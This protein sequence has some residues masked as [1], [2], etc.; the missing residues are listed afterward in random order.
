M[1]IFLV[2]Y[3]SKYAD[4]APDLL[5]L[6]L[7]CSFMPSKDNQQNTLSTVIEEGT[8]DVNFCSSISQL[9]FSPVLMCTKPLRI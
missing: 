4:D 8:G 7:V 9:F 2:G 5:D 6:E 3:T 1:F